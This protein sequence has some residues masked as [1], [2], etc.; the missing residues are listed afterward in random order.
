MCE[1]R[2]YICEHCGN[3]VGMIHDA[4]VPMMCC[5]QKMTRLEAVQEMLDAK[6]YTNLRQFLGEWNE[7]D[8]AACMDELTDE[9]FE[10]VMNKIY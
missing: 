5:G 9:E 8:I 2:F 7:A 3:I 4:G 1:N 6:Q 10:L